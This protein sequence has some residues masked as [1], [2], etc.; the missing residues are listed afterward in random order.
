MKG[1]TEIKKVIIIFV[2]T[3]ILCFLWNIVHHTIADRA[4]LG[5]ER[6]PGQIWMQS[7]TNINNSSNG[8][9]DFAGQ[10]WIQSDTNI[11]HELAS[12]WR[13]DIRDSLFSSIIKVSDYES[14]YPVSGVYVE[15]YRYATL[16]EKIINPINATYFFPDFDAMYV[17]DSN[18]IVKFKTLSKTDR[19]NIYSKEF[20]TLHFFRNEKE[21]SIEWEQ[22]HGINNR[23]GGPS[24][25][26]YLYRI[27]F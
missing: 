8:K 6:I 25:F 4:K 23:E 20:R 26:P 21:L 17:T 3:I 19:Y 2:S 22:I 13:I 18:G 11:N 10:I 5:S 7:N 1:K 15:R 16:L 9:A 27:D 14:G 12:D 24:D